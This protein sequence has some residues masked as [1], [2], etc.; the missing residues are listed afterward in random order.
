MA[1]VKEV[2]KQGRLVLPKKWREQHLKT[3]KV[4]VTIEGERLII[5]PFKPVDLSKYFDSIEDLKA[6][7]ADWKAVKRELHEIH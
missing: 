5:E 2:D 6:D 7:L 3:G 1:I 4:L